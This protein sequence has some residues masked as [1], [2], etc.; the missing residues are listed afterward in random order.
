M[1]ASSYPL[2]AVI[3]GWLLIVGGAAGLVAIARTA[4]E[5]YDALSRGERPEDM[6]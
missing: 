2:V 5:R 3:V 1:S 6:P 4:S